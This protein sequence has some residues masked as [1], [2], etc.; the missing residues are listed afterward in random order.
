MEV[1][2]NDMKQES[3]WKKKVD[4]LRNTFYRMRQE[5]VRLHDKLS[6]VTENKYAANEESPLM[7]TIRILE[8]R[9]DK[10]MIKY[11]EAQSIRKTYE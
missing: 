11:N 10:V 2:T 4:D 7:R 8:N 5:E 3:F 9:L 1:V 6:E